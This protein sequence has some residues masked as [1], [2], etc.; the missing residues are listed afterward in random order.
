MDIYNYMDIYLYIY[1][2]MDYQ[3]LAN[4]DA[5]PS[6]T[7]Q[8]K[9]RLQLGWLRRLWRC[10]SVAIEFFKARDFRINWWYT[11]GGFRPISSVLGLLFFCQCR[12][13][14]TSYKT[15]FFYIKDQLPGYGSNLGTRVPKMESLTAKSDR[16]RRGSEPMWSMTARLALEPTSSSQ[17]TTLVT[18][19]S[20]G[21]RTFGF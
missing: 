11:V 10:A 8:R 7:S 20:L 6:I 1:I 15:D 13:I 18:R 12:N 4:W 17:L 9:P 5:H 14:G 2:Y 3:P 16:K 19:Q 21:H